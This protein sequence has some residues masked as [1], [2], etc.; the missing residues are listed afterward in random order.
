VNHVV[1]SFLL[2]LDLGGA[3]V[4]AL[5]GGMMGVRHR[6][7]LFGVLVLSF[8]AAVVGGIIR[9]LLIGAVPPA[10]IGDWRYLAVPLVAGLITFF[11]SP[12]I[13]RIRHPV[14]M[15]DAVGLAI[16]AVAGTS[17]ALDYHLGPVAA[18]M[19]GMLTG[20]G[21]GMVRDLLVL[22]VPIV[23]RAE[24]YAVAAMA[25]AS[26]VVIGRALNLPAAPT[27]ICGAAVCF[28]LRLTAIR[29]DWHLPRA[30]DARSAG[31]APESSTRR[32]RE[33]PE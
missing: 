6:L 2:A 24:L 16:F 20:I 17:K 13:G 33:D 28:G 29:Y 31:T 23:L 15:L 5:S 3:F 8:T 11:W 1:G 30:R 12:A 4:F 9:D 27:A 14:Q 26:I 21:G 19:L 32:R 25:G 10:A 22:E 7:D 18:A